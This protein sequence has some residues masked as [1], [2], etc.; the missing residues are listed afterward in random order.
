MSDNIYEFMTEDLS[1]KV[2]SIL[3][4]RYSYLTSDE[5]FKHLNDL[6]VSRRTLLRELEKDNYIRIK[7]KDADRAYRR[8]PELFETKKEN[9]RKNFD[10][11]KVF[12]TLGE[13]AEKLKIRNKIQA[14]ICKTT[15]LSTT[16][17]EM[18]VGSLTGSDVVLSS[19]LNNYYDVELLFKARKKF[20]LNLSDKERIDLLILEHSINVLGPLRDIENLSVVKWDSV[21]KEV[22]KLLGEYAVL[23]RDKEWV[24]THDNHVYVNSDII[25]NIMTLLSICKFDKT[26][27]LFFKIITNKAFPDSIS[28]NY[29]EWTEW[30]NRDF[31]PEISK[32]DYTDFLLTEIIHNRDELLE[33]ALGTDDKGVIEIFRKVKQWLAKK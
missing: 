23:W 19:S 31:L 25:A 14:L 11:R 17:A 9:I 32:S 21:E 13:Q 26:Y 30:V 4:D 24:E 12:Y 28:K 7:G 15:A 20:E 5:I 29:A 22:L 3:S 10:G 1:Q 18:I 27:R 33:M 8:T 16:R 2:V 6:D